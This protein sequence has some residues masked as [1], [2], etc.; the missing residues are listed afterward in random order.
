MQRPRKRSMEDFLWPYCGVNKEDCRCRSSLVTWLQAFRNAAWVVVFVVPCCSSAGCHRVWK[1]RKMSHGK[2]VNIATTLLNV[3]RFARNVANWDCMRAFSSTVSSV[4]VVALYK[5]SR[6]VCVCRK[7]LTMKCAFTPSSVRNC[8][9]KNTREREE[10][11][12]IMFK[13][14]IRAGK[15]EQ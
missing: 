12:S 6:G 5:V 9:C 13:G 10:A 4:P 2:N 1:S 15:Y 8:S 3:A 7:F 11:A 14:K